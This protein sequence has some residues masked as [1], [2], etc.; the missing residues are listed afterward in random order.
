[1]WIR[2]STSINHGH[3]FVS[4]RAAE[5]IPIAN[6]PP[7]TWPTDAHRRRNTCTLGPRSSTLRRLRAATQDS[8]DRVWQ[9]WCK[10]MSSVVRRKG[11]V[12]RCSI[13]CHRRTPS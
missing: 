12:C 1:M 3:V 8:L 9:A 6:L 5:R 11:L 4:Y 2:R 13:G 7:Y 10:S